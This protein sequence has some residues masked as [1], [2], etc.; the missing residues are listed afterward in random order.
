[1]L[2][3]AVANEPV[4][5]R[6]QVRGGEPMAYVDLGERPAAEVPTHSAFGSE[7]QNERSL[8]PRILYATPEMADFVKTGGL[9]E[10]AGAL[11]RA[12]RRHYDVRVLIPGY[13]SVLAGLQ[14]LTIVARLGAFAG[15]PAC[16]LGYGTTPDGLG[17]YVLIAPDLYVR[18]GTPYG[19]ARGDFGDNDLRFARLG[20]A[21]AE[22]AA[23]LDPFWSADLLHLNDWQTALAPAYMAWLGIRRPS[24]L[25]IH[26]LAYQGLFP[27]EHLGRIGAPDY[28]FQMDGVEFYG[29][30]S[31]LKAGLYHAS[32]VTTVSD[33][34]AREITTPEGGCGLDGLLGP[35]RR[36]DGSPASSTG[37][38][39]AGTR[40]PIRI[41]PRRSRRMTGRASAPMPTRCASSSAWRSRAGRSSPSSPASCIRRASISASLR[42]NPSSPRAGSL[43]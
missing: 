10:V 27:R 5:R 40:A 38:T 33:T 30:L 13:A 7:L 31:F 24:V 41:W 36:R 6:R 29:Q 28:A 23:G 19:D 16:D 14:G 15:V 2:S 17:V 18:D 42:R 3:A 20:R 11:P 32:H 43:W 9:G 12:L 34:Y 1:M 35:V 21:A 8:L 22:L 26:N 4:R 25:T 39:K 37:S